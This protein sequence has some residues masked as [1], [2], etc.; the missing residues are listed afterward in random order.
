MRSVL[1]NRR[2]EHFLKPSQVSEVE[3]A[4]A[5]L[6]AKKWKNLGDYVNSLSHAE[7]IALASL[8]H[9]CEDSEKNSD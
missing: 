8:I 7:S 9:D 5:K 2:D 6:E 1:A 3:S 4:T